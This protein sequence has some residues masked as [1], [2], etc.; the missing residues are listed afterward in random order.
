MD[1]KKKVR[2]SDIAE[3]LNISTVTV[4]KALANKDGVGDDL[5]KQI[6]DMAEE[7][8]YKVTEV[9]N[10]VNQHY[11]TAVNCFKKGIFWK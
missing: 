11:N 5:R 10:N 9:A 3:K 4:S 8:G 6:K 1:K 7:M 2:L